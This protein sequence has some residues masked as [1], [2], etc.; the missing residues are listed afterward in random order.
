MGQFHAT[1]IF[2][3]QHNGSVAMAGDGQVTFGNSMVMKH[4]AKKVRRLYHGEVLAGFA[5]S[6]ADAITLFEKFEGKL[7]EYHG[8]L[9]RAAVEMAKEWRMDKV[10]QRLEAMM[11]V[12]NKDS[13][14]LIS[15]NGEIIE[16]DDGI[17]AIGSGGSFALAAGRA[18]KKYAPHLSAREIA[19]ASLLTAA[20]ICVFTNT[21]LVVDELN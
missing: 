20:E 1:T 5:G 14:L 4:G 7:E 16:P 10:L 21:N 19:E 2:A 18:L 17:L 9:Q 3:I 8:N 11:I 15:G 13:L 12:L 6:V